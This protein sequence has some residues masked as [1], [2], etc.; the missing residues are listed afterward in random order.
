MAAA[1]GQP[2]TASMTH[3]LQAGG[4]RKYPALGPSV[5]GRS[6]R[7]SF[8][9]EGAFG[10]GPRYS[11]LQSS[12]SSWVR[13]A[14]SWNMSVARYSNV[15]KYQL[16]VQSGFA[17]PNEHAMMRLLCSLIVSDG[18]ALDG[19]NRRRAFAF[20]VRPACCTLRHGALPHT[21]LQRPPIRR[22]A[23]N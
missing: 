10:S 1:T 15:S 23:G 19:H 11:G 9:G 22:D 20:S 8:F 3:T 2:Q 7:K 13:H 6:K 4:P 14:S 18:R 5:D 16:P 21:D 12:R 17:C